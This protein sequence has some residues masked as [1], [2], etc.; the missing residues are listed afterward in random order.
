MPRDRLVKLD[1][2]EMVFA[3][4]GVEALGCV[5][6]AVSEGA[7]TPSEGASAGHDREIVHRRDRQWR[8]SSKVGRTRESDYGDPDDEQ[9]RI[10]QIARLQKLAQPFLKRKGKRMKVATTI[11]GAANHAA[12]L[13]FLI[14]YGKPQIDEPLSDACE[15]CAQSA[16]WKDCCDEFKFLF[17]GTNIYALSR[18]VSF[19]LTAWTVSTSSA[20]RFDTS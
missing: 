17:R 13:A 12:V 19:S 1:L 14:R 15:R 2:P 8:T 18:L 7:I 11:K 9:A 3:D 4:D 16:A 5:M 6:R 20:R 10:R